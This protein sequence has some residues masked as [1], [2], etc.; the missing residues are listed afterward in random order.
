MNE[1][2]KIIVAFLLVAVVFTST[3]ILMLRQGILPSWNPK[4]SDKSES[5]KKEE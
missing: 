4:D 5:D 3:V 1:T 2:I